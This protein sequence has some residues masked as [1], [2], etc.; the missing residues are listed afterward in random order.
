MRARRE[1]RSRALLNSAAFLTL[2]TAAIHFAVAPEHFGM[3][4]PY[5]IF[6]VLLGLTQV[7]L[8]VA[9]L[10]VPQRSLFIAAAL[11]TLAVI[12]LYLASRTFG[13]PIAPVPWRPEP[14][15]FPDVAA[16]LMEAVTVIQFLR[17][18]RRPRKV[19]RGRIRVGLKMIPGVLL[20]SLASFVGVGSA[21]TPMLAAYNAAP[22]VPGQASTSVADLIA[23][24]G[25]EPVKS[26]ALTAAVTNIGGNQA[27][28]FNG[29][30]PGPLLRVTQGDRVRVLLVNHLPDTTSI[31]WHGFRLPN[32]EDGVAGITQNAVRPGGSYVYEFIAT[33]AGTFWYHSHQDTSGQVPRGLFGPIIVDPRAGGIHETRDYSLTIHNLPGTFSV[34]VNGTTNLHL[35]ARPGDTVRLR[36]IS[37]WPAP[38]PQTPVLIGAPYTIAALDGHD[39][40]Q[41]QELGPERIA[42]GMGQRADLVFT[43]P[44]TG[45]VRLVG[46]EGFAPPWASASTAGVTIGDGP[47]PRM[48][49]PGSLP[50]FDLTKYGVSASDPVVDA[51]R[52]D[53][54]HQITLGFG[55]PLF[56]D[57]KFDGVDTF[58][59]QHSPFVTPIR[60]REGDLVRL[61]IV[62]RTDTWH[63]IHIHGHVF[64]ILAKNGRPLS[65]SPV[66]V[67]AVLVGPNETWDVAFKAD[68]PGIWML[69]CHV[70]GHAAHGMSM[71]INYEGI[72]T[73][74]T[75]G[76]RSGNI[77]E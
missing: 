68:N 63:S 2:S 60:V 32:A 77:P 15:G 47:A 13:L 46:L 51:G 53:H 23:S 61:H 31:H 9:I 45:S 70:L 65:G 3:Y 71:T 8:A 18:I 55:G 52:Y 37:A 1:E 40:N 76:T 12:G 4:V 69:H 49:D 73:P 72:S 42:L 26:F 30:V 20:A 19:R 27:W 54:T 5:G 56:Y 10:F 50:R 75:M 21:L 67:D 16:T 6:F 11:G 7:A 35:D 64:S 66:H 38:D 62:N 48:I 74:F 25:H 58:N 17:L 22:A 28:A 43:M 33:D 14:V 41:P 36:L 34:G 59:G 39:L 57:S 24:P 44:A 29:Q